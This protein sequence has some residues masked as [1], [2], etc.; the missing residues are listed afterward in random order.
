V[1]SNCH[2]GGFKAHK[3]SSHCVLQSE[4]SIKHEI[5]L[6]GPVVGLMF[7]YDDFFVY[8]DGVYA[9]MATANPVMTAALQQANRNAVQLAV[10]II[11]WGMEN[12]L[13]YWL[14]ENSYGREWG[15]N[16]YA[17]ILRS[18]K[19]DEFSFATYNPARERDIIL[20]E[21]FTI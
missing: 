9:P 3:G 16:G 20:L 19:E 8:K 17:K 10:K 7:L 6:S 18:G 4:K 15:Q 11:G 13:D 1:I 21:P 12:G 2:N 14:I 5:L